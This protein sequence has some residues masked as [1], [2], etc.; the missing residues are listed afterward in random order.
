MK[1]GPWQ[2]VGCGATR[3]IIGG[4]INNIKD[5]YAFI[6]KTPRIRIRDV[7]KFDSHPDHLNWAARD[8]KGDGPLDQDARDW[9]DAALKIFGY[10]LED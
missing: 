3:V 7:S 10:E 6:E 2:L 4:N 8:Y 9:C 5:R 1:I